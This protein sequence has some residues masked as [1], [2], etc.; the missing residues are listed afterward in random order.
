MS[1]P[2]ERQ[3]AIMTRLSILMFIQFFI[4]GSWYLSVSLYMLE[5]GMGGGRFYAY[6]AGPLAAM[7]APFFTGLVADRFFNTEKVLAFL[8]LGAGVSMLALPFVAGPENTTLFNA[9]ILVHM[10]FYMPTLGLTASMSFAH[11]P[12]G[13]EQFPLVR[14]W[15]TIGWIVGGFILTFAFVTKNPD[16]T[17]AVAGEIKDAQFW[18]GGGAAVLLGIFCFTLPK[19]P[20]PKKNEPVNARD[21][22][23]MDAWSQLKNPS[24]ATFIFC[25]FLVCIPLAAYYASLQQQMEAMGIDHI[26]AWK[27]TGTFIEAGMM[28]LMPFFFRKLGIKWMIVIGI[29]A[30]ALRY[31]LFALGATPEGF[32]L[33]LAGICLHGIC[34]DFFFVTGQV[35]VDRSTPHNIRGQAQGM[36]IFF[37]QG[38]GL[39]IGAMVTQELAGRAFGDTIVSTSP[40]SLE[41]WPKIW[42][43]LCIMATAVMIIFFIVFKEN[44]TTGDESEGAAADA[45]A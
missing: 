25:S 2:G 39:F 35:Y 32:A 6:T 44:G 23:F 5:H 29:A 19:T 12:K 10:L 45:P 30:W 43:P 14:L 21:L 42:W 8:F 27:N 34:Y 15:G 28:F 22:F 37:T 11:L 41:F 33:V 24:F 9:V 38:L 16:G 17:V 4:W 3:P 31:V 13:S 40:E 18:L 26:A 36:N 20:A 1:L 7:I